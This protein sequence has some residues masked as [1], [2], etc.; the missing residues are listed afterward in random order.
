MH[1]GYKIISNPRVTESIDNDPLFTIYPNPMLSN[2]IKI[3]TEIMYEVFIYTSDGQEIYRGK[4]N[5]GVNDLT[6]PHTD[7][8]VYFVKL[9]D[10]GGQV[11]I[12]KIMKL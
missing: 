7:H 4:V 8:K 6:I 5:N 3:Q 2:H 12:K 1:I 11:I 10:A 9:I